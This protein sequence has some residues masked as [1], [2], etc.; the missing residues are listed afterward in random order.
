MSGI[1]R[2]EEGTGVA[3]GLALM[4]IGAALGMIIIMVARSCDREP[5][6]AVTKQAACVGCHNRTVALVNYFKK[7]GSRSPQ[8]MADAVL[9]SHRNSRLLAAVAVVES[10]GNPRVVRSG[11]KGR[12]HGAFQVNPR[13]WQDV[14]LDAAGQAKQAERII[15]ELLMDHNGIVPALNAYGGDKTHKKYALNVLK[16]LQNVP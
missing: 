12:H 1:Y 8:E 2:G 4:I 5:M 10:G 6:P 7:S 11:Y 3:G 9:N 14:P 16:E 13:H 15:E